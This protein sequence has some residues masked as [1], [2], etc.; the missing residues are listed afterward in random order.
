[1]V[2]IFF[3]SR[4]KYQLPEDFERFNYSFI[5]CLNEVRNGFHGK[6]VQYIGVSHP[7]G[8]L[9]FFDAPCNMLCIDENARVWSFHPDAVDHARLKVYSLNPFQMV[10]PSRIQHFR[11]LG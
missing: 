5:D 4:E 9:R 10:R 3:P 8:N 2:D 7:R 11:S 6:T 1:D